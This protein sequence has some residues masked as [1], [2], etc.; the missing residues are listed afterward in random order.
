MDSK[1]GPPSGCKK[2]RVVAVNFAIADYSQFLFDSFLKLPAA[3]KK[4]AC[5]KSH[6]V[7]RGR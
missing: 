3:L 5:G 1:S 2:G 7:Y 4:G 6:K